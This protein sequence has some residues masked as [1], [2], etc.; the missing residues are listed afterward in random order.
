MLDV[1]KR[2]GDCDEAFL[3]EYKVLYRGKTGRTALHC[4][5]GKRNL[6]GISLKLTSPDT[7]QQSLINIAGTFGIIL[8][9]HF[10]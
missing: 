10:Y 5:E 7:L 4:T 9:K 3:Q 8:S 2:S 6:Q 1:Q